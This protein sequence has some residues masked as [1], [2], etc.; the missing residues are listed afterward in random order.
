MG[1][2]GLM[3]FIAKPFSF[4]TSESLDFEKQYSRV[5][6]VLLVPHLVCIPFFSHHVTPFTC[7][8]IALCIRE[9]LY[10][11][12]KLDPDLSFVCARG[13][14]HPPSLYLAPYHAPNKRI[15]PTRPTR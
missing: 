11:V 2:L 6:F 13:S 5:S 14:L 8:S 7:M 15:L 10:T 3:H 4:P 12:L 1:P 9:A